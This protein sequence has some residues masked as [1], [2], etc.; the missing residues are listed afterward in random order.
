MIKNRYNHSCTLLV[1][2]LSNSVMAHGYNNTI[3]T[4]RRTQ[5]KKNNG[6]TKESKCFPLNSTKVDHVVIVIIQ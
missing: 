2:K 5:E 6:I 4:K 3:L 1:R